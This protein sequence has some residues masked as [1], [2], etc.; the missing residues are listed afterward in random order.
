VLRVFAGYLERDRIPSRISN[1][2][3]LKASPWMPVGLDIFESGAPARGV[4]P[5][6][7]GNRA[8]PEVISPQNV[9]LNPAVN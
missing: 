4:I 9:P 8:K 5:P 3:V 6:E 2:R 7:I 1:S